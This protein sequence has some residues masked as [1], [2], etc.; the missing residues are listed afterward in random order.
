MALYNIC[1]LLTGGEGEAEPGE[2]RHAGDTVP[3]SRKLRWILRPCLYQNQVLC[4]PGEDFMK[5][6]I[7]YELRGRES[8]EL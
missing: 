6:R 1:V 3:L 7:K 5:A 4:L 2:G 8:R